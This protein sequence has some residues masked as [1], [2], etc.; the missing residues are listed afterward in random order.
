MW[1]IRPAARFGTAA[2]AAAALLLACSQSGPLAGVRPQAL[3][4][5]QTFSAVEG[6]L[7][8]VGVMPFYP[9]PELARQLE[10]GDLSRDD[11]ADLVSTYF[12]EALRGMDVAVISPSDIALAFSNQGR[13][14]SRKDPRTVAEVV[15]KEFGLSAIISGEVWRWRDRDGEAYGSERPASVGF[16]AS[17]FEVEQG[18]RL[19]RGRF[20]HTQRTISGNIF[21]A[22]QYPGG[23]TRWLTITEL[24][25]WGARITV[26]TLVDGQWR[27]SK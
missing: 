20:D 7:R 10:G 18:R 19:W 11:V 12:A 16:E 27:V 25:R 15:A 5:E 9:R 4:K 26:Q 8:V 2:F 23:G 22:S 3:V 21:A 13:A 6:S 14:L 1:L 24:A 17:L